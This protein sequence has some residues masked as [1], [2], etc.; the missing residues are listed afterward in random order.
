L[1]KPKKEEEV[2]KVTILLILL[3][4]LCFGQPAVVWSFALQPHQMEEELN[5]AFST[6][7]MMEQAQR[8]AESMEQAQRHAAIQEAM[9][10]KQAQ[11]EAEEAA[12]EAEL[13]AAAEDSSSGLKKFMIV[14]GGLLASMAVGAKFLL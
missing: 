9:A 4:V 10:A 11:I 7:Q 2:M 12:A 5:D 1:D 6:E 14:A 13:A 3:A 8:H